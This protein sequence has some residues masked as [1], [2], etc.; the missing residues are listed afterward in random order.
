VCPRLWRHS[1]LLIHGIAL[2]NLKLFLLPT[3][4][5]CGERNRKYAMHSLPWWLS[6]ICSLTHMS[7][8]K[9]KFLTIP[10]TK[11]STW[12]HLQV[13]G[14]LLAELS[15][16]VFTRRHL[17]VA[18]PSWILLFFARA[19]LLVGGKMVLLEWPRHVHK[20][21]LTACPRWPQAVPA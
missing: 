5:L 1:L 19:P 7:A 14:L 20:C 10:L 17:L 3:P 21:S 12:E 11:I 6:L 16:L 2:L 13:Q 15:L 9:E 4:H 18:R 8:R